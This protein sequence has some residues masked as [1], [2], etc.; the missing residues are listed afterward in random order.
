MQ[1]QIAVGMVSR[2]RFVTSV[3]TLSMPRVL[4]KW[5]QQWRKMNLSPLSLARA[6]ERGE[7]PP[8][9]Y[10]PNLATLL[11]HARKGQR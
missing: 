5:M 3:T 11:P 4:K 7:F 6:R 8:P 10:S 9:S 2:C 1:L